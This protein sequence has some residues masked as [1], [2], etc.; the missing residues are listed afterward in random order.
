[1]NAEPM[2]ENLEETLASK[3]QSLPVL[4]IEPSRG[5][6]ALQLR[7]LWEYRELLYFL[8]WR[9]I[10]VRYKQTVLGIL[11]AVLQPVLMMLVFM[12]TIGRMTDFKT[13]IPYALFVLAAL[14]PWTFFSTGMSQASNS[15]VGSA[16]LI[17]KIYFPRLVMP[18]ASVLAGIVDFAVAFVVM[19]VVMIFYGVAPGWTMLWMPAMLLL[20]FVGALGISLWLSAM[21][22]QFRDVRHAI[23]FL[24]QFMFFASAIFYPISELPARFQRIYSL[25]PMVGVAEGFRWLVAGGPAPLEAIVISS[26]SAVLILIGGAFYFRRMERTFADVV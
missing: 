23:P 12:G 19:L 1:M 8:T 24:V 25:N 14:V 16:N 18:I 22:V 9:D 4:R 10:K 26:G 21:N 17:K 20:A 11:W 13:P 6:V 3:A 2:T 7:D 15:L 5:W